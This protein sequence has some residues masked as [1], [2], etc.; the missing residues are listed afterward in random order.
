LE[1]TTT[2][3]GRIAQAIRGQ[4]W[5]AVMI[6][7][8]I[9]VLG[10]VIGLQASNWN[11]RRATEVEVRA[12]IQNLRIEFRSSRASLAATRTQLDRIMDSSRELLALFGRQDIGMSEVELDRL[13]EM[14]F[15]WPTWSPSDSV[16]RE[17]I[18]SGYLS[19]LDEDGVKPLLFEWERT[20]THVE[21]WNRRMERSSQD[22]IDYVKDHGSLRNANHDRVSIERSALEVRNRRLLSEP[23]FENYVDE[24][25]MMSQ[26]LATQ[27][28]AASDLV[29]EII[30]ASGR[31]LNEGL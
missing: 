25:L 22:L 19:V 29:D 17:L 6:E 31:F 24:K 1:R 10:V 4:N 2:I 23:R 26:F 15:F 12:L 9:I 14:T 18:N 21:E 8:G 16:S 3:F 30:G 5:R 20:L 27:Y 7:L 11:A 13:I 28:Q